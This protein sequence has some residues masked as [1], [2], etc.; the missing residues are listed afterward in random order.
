MNLKHPIVTGHRPVCIQ[1][2][3]FNIKFKIII[4]S[5][6]MLLLLINLTAPVITGFQ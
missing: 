3:T 1:N 6:Y 2:D 4:K 5:Y